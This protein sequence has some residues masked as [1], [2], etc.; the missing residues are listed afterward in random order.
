MQTTQKAGDPSM[1]EI[2]ASIRKIIADDPAALASSAQPPVPPARAEG[3]PPIQAASPFMPAAVPVKSERRAPSALDQELADLLRE[4]A[5]QPNP[6]SAL[7][8]ALGGSSVLNA[9]APMAPAVAVPLADTG[10]MGAIAGLGG[11]FRNRPNGA[12]TGAAA[13]PTDESA[14][15]VS[16]QQVS[17]HLGTAAAPPAVDAAVPEALPPS[18]VANGSAAPVSMQSILNRLGAGAAQ[19][20]DSLPTPTPA[21]A[22]TPATVMSR[23]F[24]NE[25]KPA[26]AQPEQPPSAPANRP[27]VEAPA[28]PIVAEKRAEPVIAAVAQPVAM[29]A[30]IPA[31]A[32][33]PIAAPPA[34]QAVA[35]PQ[36]LESTVPAAMEAAAAPTAVTAAAEQPKAAGGAVKS[37][38]DTLA[39]LLRP[40]VRQWLDENMARALEKAVKIEMAD[41][42]KSAMTKLVPGAKS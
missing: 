13:A 20:T 16:A 31:T 30:P 9:P 2:L 25:P 39:E 27:P 1:E 8:T 7:A 10:D 18:P 42:V 15:P 29:P 23:V 34:P 12:A 17:P 26:M 41:S 4:P 28:A 21:G 6:A 14:G 19:A 24:A 22:P 36:K 35:K 32:P 3:T 5:D 33:V 11:W 37:L 38:D 40:V